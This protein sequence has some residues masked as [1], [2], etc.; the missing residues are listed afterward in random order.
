LGGVLCAFLILNTI[1]KRIRNLSKSNSAPI[2]KQARAVISL[3]THDQETAISVWALEIKP[4]NNFQA[5]CP[6]LTLS[7][8]RA[9]HFAVTHKVTY[10]H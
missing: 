1:R 9:P 4:G 5:S 10:Q 7:G 6:L 2:A 8:S 3:T